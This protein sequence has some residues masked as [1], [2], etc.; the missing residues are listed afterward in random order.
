MAVDEVLHRLS[1]QVSDRLSAARFHGWDLRE[2]TVTEILLL[3]LLEAIG[4]ATRIHGVPSWT[5]RSY[6]LFTMTSS[7]PPGA[8]PSRC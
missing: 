5:R 4:T 1:V 6:P 3:D 8:S 2:E 7:D